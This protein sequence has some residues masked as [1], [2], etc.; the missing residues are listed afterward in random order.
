MEPFSP[1]EA[2]LRHA[3]KI[4]NSIIS[5]INELLADRIY[6][7]VIEIT[8]AELTEKVVRE[9]YSED[10]FIDKG[11]IEFE[12]GYRVHGW[13]VEYTRVNGKGIWT[14]KPSDGK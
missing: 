12:A 11:W 7:G 5:M 9:G 1:E 6:K 4:P 8:Q 3:E 13:S 2:R 14:F 10:E